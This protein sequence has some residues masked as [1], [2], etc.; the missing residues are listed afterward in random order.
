MFSLLCSGHLLMHE[1]PFKASSKEIT[2][3][4]SLLWAASGSAACSA[5]SDQISGY[6][7]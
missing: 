6:T 3:Q 4:I 2:R 1:L 5:R 7:R